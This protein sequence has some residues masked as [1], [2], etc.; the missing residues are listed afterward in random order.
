MCEVLKN[1]VM[2]VHC[3]V[4]IADVELAR[5]VDFFDLLIGIKR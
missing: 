5:V 3:C 4:C 1:Q 2:F